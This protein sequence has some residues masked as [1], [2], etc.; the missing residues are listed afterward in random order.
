MILSLVVLEEE[1]IRLPTDEELQNLEVHW[2]TANA[3]WDPLGLSEPLDP[4]LPVPL[5]YTNTLG[6]MDLLD[7]DLEWE[8]IAP[9]QA[10]KVLTEEQVADELT[11]ALRYINFSQCT[12]ADIY[13][14][15]ATPKEDEYQKYQPFLGWKPLEVIK[16]T[17]E[18]TI[19]SLQRS[20]LAPHFVDTTSLIF[21]PL[22][23]QG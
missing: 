21:L 8:N 7:L 13:V 17:F 3:P 11:Q 18:A 9:V 2:L 14:N 23:S 15:Q 4:T 16:R 5:G 19:P 1:L 20:V 22:T 12:Q 6:T 10:G